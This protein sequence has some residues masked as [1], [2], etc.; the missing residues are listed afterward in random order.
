MAVGRSHIVLCPGTGVDG[1][2]NYGLRGRNNLL[3]VPG[4][5]VLGVAD[6]VSSANMTLNGSTPEYLF[7]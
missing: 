1:N 2:P 3:W 4:M 7:D 5:A 6:P